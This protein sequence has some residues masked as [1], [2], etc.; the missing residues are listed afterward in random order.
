MVEIEL[1]LEQGLTWPLVQ[2]SHPAELTHS[3]FISECVKQEL[4]QIDVNIGNLELYYLNKP[5]LE[6]VVDATGNIV[7]DQTVAIKTFW[8]QG[9]KIHNDMLH[10]LGNYYP[11]YRDDFLTYCDQHEI[12]V[13]HGPLNCLKFWHAGTWKFI[14]CENFWQFYAYQRKMQAMQ[15]PLAKDHMGYSVEQISLQLKKLKAMLQ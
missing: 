1:Y 10:I 14:I 2:F 13:E 5:S 9:I 11:C 15:V 3:T 12:I 4:W 7:K 8:F 6:T